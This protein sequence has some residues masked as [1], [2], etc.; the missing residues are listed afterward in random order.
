MP[1]C[2]AGC[3]LGISILFA[4]NVQCAGP[5]ADNGKAVAAVQQLGVDA[6]SDAAALGKLRALIAQDRVISPTAGSD[7]IEEGYWSG[8]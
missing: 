2:L 7:D 6:R 3:L 4:S 5:A 1:R 8:D